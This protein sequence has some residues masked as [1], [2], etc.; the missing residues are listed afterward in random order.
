MAS[1]FHP[2]IQRFQSLKRLRLDDVDLAEVATEHLR[3]Y[4]LHEHWISLQVGVHGSSVSFQIVQCVASD[5]T[6]C[7]IP[8]LAE[9]A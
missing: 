6:R 2:T 9:P 1:Q 8:Q 4:P 7:R 3:H 5:A